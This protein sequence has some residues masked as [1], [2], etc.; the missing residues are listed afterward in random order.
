[1][2]KISSLL[3]IGLTVLGTSCKK[4]LDIN[5]NPNAPAT[6]TITPSLLL[7]Q[8]LTTTAGIVNGYNTMGAQ[9][10]GF[11]ANAG[12]YGG[13]GVSIT[14]NFTTSNFNGQFTGPYDN[15]EDYQTILD[16]TEGDA[17][18]SYYN[19]AARIMKAY[20]YLLLVDAYND[21]PY[22]EALKGSEVLTPKYDQGPAIYKSL[23]EE[24]DAAIAAI[25]TGAST[26]GIQELAVTDVLFH[27]DMTKWKQFA[28]TLKLKLMVQGQGKVTFSNTSF[29]ADGFLATD[30]IV[31]PGYVKDAGKQNPKWATWG[32][33]STGSSGNKA[34]LPT[35]FA[36]AF[37]NGVKLTDPGRGAAIYYQYPN[38]PTNR[39]G[40]EGT[41]ISASPEGSFWYPSSNRTGSSAG[42]ASGVLKGSAAGM[43]ILTAAESYFLQAEAAVKGIVAGDAKALFESGIV[44][45]F[46]YL[47]LK[48]D[49]SSI[50]NAVADAANYI[51]TNDTSPLVNFDLATT[52]EMKIEA[53]ITQKY[54]AMN[55]V[56]SDVAWNDYRRTGYPKLVNSPSASGTETFASTVSESTRPDRLP[57]RILYPSSEGAYNSANVPRNISPFTSLIFWA[58]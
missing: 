43:P 26:S 36:M 33:S 42:N 10:G 47:Y 5:Q 17:T 34:W 49:G 40:F 55:M 50:G 52:D 25:N 44:A 54:I 20:D 3:L 45:S 29:S 13:F 35:T 19:A 56:N 51:S 8:A 24:L 18:A 41:S 53:I 31:N 28:N 7:P 32:F 23:A 38:T 11:M 14:Y 15:L 48:E 2:K 22:S 39:L 6:G 21:V 30:A 1:M 57:S 58:K 27:G 37:Y 9:L 12:G 46:Q 16:R 4:Y